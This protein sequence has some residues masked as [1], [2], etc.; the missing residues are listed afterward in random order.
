MIL[1]PS[2]KIGVAAF[3]LKLGFVPSSLHCSPTACVALPSLPGGLRVS[4]PPP[5]FSFP[6][7]ATSTFPAFARSSARPL[8]PTRFISFKEHFRLYPFSSKPSPTA[9]TSETPPSSEMPSN[10]PSLPFSHSLMGDLSLVYSP[11]SAPVHTESPRTRGAPVTRVPLL[12][13]GV[14]PKVLF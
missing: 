13:R 10:F 1:Y 12:A 9:H 11:S 5:S 14:C 3:I 2:Q 8:L 6:W 4:A 7:A